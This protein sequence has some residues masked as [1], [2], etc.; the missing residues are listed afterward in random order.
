[1][2]NQN[3]QSMCDLREV[4]K[5]LDRDKYSEM[6]RLEYQARKEARQ[7]KRLGEAVY[8]AITTGYKSSLKPE[9]RQL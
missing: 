2:I 7:N 3:Y 4:Y 1:M 9:N 5:Q 6:K 8:N